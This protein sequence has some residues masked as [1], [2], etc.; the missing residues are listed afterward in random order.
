MQVGIQTRTLVKPVAIGIQYYAE[1]HIADFLIRPLMLLDF[2][3]GLIKRGI[4][5]PV[6]IAF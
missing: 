1:L 3:H 5:H 4:D 6:N 2:E